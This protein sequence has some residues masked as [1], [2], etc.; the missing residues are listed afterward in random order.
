MSIVQV[1]GYSLN[2][3]IVYNVIEMF[4]AGG[5]TVIHA[6]GA[7]FGITVSYILGKSLAPK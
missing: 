1:I 7:Y 5:S 3:Y 6:F 2:E 4:D